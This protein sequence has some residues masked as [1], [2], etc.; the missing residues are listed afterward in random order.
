MRVKINFGIAFALVIT[1]GIF[2]I[3]ATYD[4]LVPASRE[5]VCR[6]QLSNEYGVH[7][8]LINLKRRTD[9]LKEMDNQLIKLNLSYTL[10]EAFDSRKPLEK[11]PLDDGFVS[12]LPLSSL[13]LHTGTHM[14]WLSHMH[15]LL[16][17]VKGLYGNGSLLILEDDAKLEENFKLT[18]TD[19]F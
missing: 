5:T 10:F 11:Q 3:Y 17:Y 8:V 14:C 9:R 19:F 7:T 2:T 13:T 6:P 18:I 16:N 12:K 4:F 15:V 1:I